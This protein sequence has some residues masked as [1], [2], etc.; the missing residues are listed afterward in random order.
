MTASGNKKIDRRSRFTISSPAFVQRRDAVW[1]I[2]LAAL[3]YRILIYVFYAGA[4]VVKG[5]QMQNILHAREFANGNY[6]GVLDVYWAPLYPILI[7]IVSRLTNSPL[8][9]ATV[10]SIAAGAAAVPL[11]YYF[12]REFY[13]ATEAVIAASIAVFFPHLINSVFEIGTENIYFLTLIGAVLTGWRGLQHQDAKYFL[14]AGILL[15]L[16]YLTR[17]EAFGYLAFFII[18]II[19]KNRL[20]NR[21]NG[22]RPVLQIAA[23]LLGFFVLATPYLFYLRQATGHLTISGKAQANLAAG[24][25]EPDDAD[26]ENNADAVAGRDSTSLRDAKIIAV[27]FAR[28]LIEIQKILTFLVPSLLM[29]PVGLGLF[30]EIWKSE[31]AEKELYLISFVLVTIAGY[32]LAV[33]QTRYFYILLPIFFGWMARG[34]IR[35]GEWLQQTALHS[36]PF[37]FQRLVDFRIVL[38]AAGFLL[39]LYLL[40]INFFMRPTEKS[41]KENAFEERDAGLWLKSH[42]K[43]NATVFS[44]SLRPVFYAEAKQVL[45][46]S[47]NLEDVLRQLKNQPV[48]YIITSERSLLRN[49][50]LKNL[51]AVLR[52]SP[53]YRIVYQQ[54]EPARYQIVVFQAK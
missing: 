5:D 18:F 44:A 48:D 26:S 7:G 3:G 40:P 8:T 43:P 51:D 12:V 35:L 53:D 41:W 49:P 39:F 38:A 29:L 32:A 47:E 4:I 19:V 11:I 37:R 2:T 22:S 14:L 20:L 10:L 1:M 34:F 17:P 15:G 33:S 16:A 42:G 52:N 13:G 27:A 6:Y 50:Y 24:L 9:A 23:L 21:T 30:G 46:V 54:N 25:L 31:R 36:M 28:S 45:P